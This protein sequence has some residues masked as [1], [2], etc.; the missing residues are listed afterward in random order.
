MLVWRYIDKNKTT[1]SAMRD[2][3]NMKHIIET[4][5]ETIKTDGENPA[6]S[7]FETLTSSKISANTKV[8]KSIE[9]ID[10][11]KNRYRN[12]AEY[13][14]WFLPAWDSLKE[15]DKKI[16]REFYMNESKRSG[17]SIRLQFDLNYSERQIDRLRAEA[18][19]TFSTLLLGA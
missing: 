10:F 16:L 18:L 7:K 12:A 9:N 11:I 17:A 19:E 1:I 13:M 2:Y 14:E 4:T 3:E 5:P 15:Q 8:V 6:Q